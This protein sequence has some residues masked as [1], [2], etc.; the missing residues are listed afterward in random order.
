MARLTFGE[1]TYVFRLNQLGLVAAHCN[2]YALSVAGPSVLDSAQRE[3][4]H[5]SLD[6]A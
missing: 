2:I 1:T 4:P 6:E 3:V 5:S